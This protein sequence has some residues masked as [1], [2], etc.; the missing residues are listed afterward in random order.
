MM[1]M[2][3]PHGLV[4]A[5]QLKLNGRRL[6]GVQTEGDSHGAMS[7]KLDSVM[8]ELIVICLLLW[9][10]SRKVTAFLAVTI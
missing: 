4:S 5:C 7:G 1:L 9:E 10:V 3:M 2:H 8:S 6:Q